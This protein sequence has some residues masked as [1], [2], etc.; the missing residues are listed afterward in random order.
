MKTD[1]NIEIELKFPLNNILALTKKLNL[2]AKQ[3]EKNNYQKDSY[4]I[5]PHRDFL[6]KKPVSEWLRIRHTKKDVFLAYKKW[7]NQ[8]NQKALSCYEIE[9]KI[10][11]NDALKKILESL[12]FK[13][14]IDVEKTRTTWKYKNTVISIDKVTEIGN[15][16]EI[17]ASGKFESRAKAVEHLYNILGELNADVG[18]QDF[19]GYPYKILEKKGYFTE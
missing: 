7:H 14:I 8:N 5:P 1:K 12:N 4:Y 13:K 17:E 18:E 3:V 19:Q 10:S 2:K 6:A 15:F 9:T 16:L 11:D